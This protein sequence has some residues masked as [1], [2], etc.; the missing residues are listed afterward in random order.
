MRDFSCYKKGGSPS[1]TF[2]ETNY[3]LIRKNNNFILRKSCHRPKNKSGAGFIALVSSI[4]IAVIL[5]TAVVSLGSRGIAGRFILL[6]IENKQVSQ[7]LAE[8]CVQSAVIA[9]VNDAEHAESDVSVPVG[10][11]TCT[12]VSV[13]P[14]TPISGQSTIKAK[15]ESR[16]ATTNLEVVADSATANFI[17]WQEVAAF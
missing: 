15:G 5:L 6:D 14:N 1:T 13:T 8:A 3:M 7:A 11:K 17:S 2:I 16:G 10:T 12:I 9:I 4:I